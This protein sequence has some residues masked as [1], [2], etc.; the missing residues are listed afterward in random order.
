MMY[1]VPV[2]GIVCTSHRLC[3][4]SCCTHVLLY[5]YAWGTT[6]ECRYFILR[7]CSFFLPVDRFQSL[8]GLHPMIL[9]HFL[10][11]QSYRQRLKLC[12]YTRIIGTTTA[13]T[14]GTN[15]QSIFSK[16]AA[17]YVLYN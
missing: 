13:D 16:T 11:I 9:V 17:L 14:L 1:Q 12:V 15:S 6:Q 3:C 4:H 7:V 2:L 8:M 5:E 10:I